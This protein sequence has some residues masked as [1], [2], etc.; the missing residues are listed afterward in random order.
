MMP[1]L[2]AFTLSADFCPDREYRL[3][4]APL[5]ESALNNRQ[6]LCWRTFKGETG[7]LELQDTG[8]LTLETLQILTRSEWV[9]KHV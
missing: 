9:R 5:I 1:I 2:S 8:I 3:L 6:S 4:S 7:L